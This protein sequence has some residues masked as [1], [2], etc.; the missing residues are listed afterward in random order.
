MVSV[1]S[2][3]ERY[4]VD[5]LARQLEVPVREVELSHGQALEV[6]EEEQQQRQQ[7]RQ[8][9]ER[10]GRSPEARG[11]RGPAGDEARGRKGPVA[12]ERGRKGGAEGG[13]AR[14]GRPPSSQSSTAA[15][16]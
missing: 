4:V 3:G 2:G 6:P 10:G 1:V 9:G 14:K 11:R 8:Q 16:A 13:R 15:S 5:K 7:K 12:E